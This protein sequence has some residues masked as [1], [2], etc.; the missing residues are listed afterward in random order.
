MKRVVFALSFLAL[1]LA[2]CDREAAPSAAEGETSVA[3]A[4]CPD[5]GARFPITGVCEGRAV[6]YLRQDTPPRDPPGDQFGPDCSW[7]TAETGFGPEQAVLYRALRCG[8]TTTTLEFGGGSH[9]AAL[10]IASS[11]IGGT[12]GVQVVQVFPL[13]SDMPPE[14]TILAQATDLSAE[15][16]AKC[17][18]LP[19]GVSGWP[20]DS[21]WITYGPEDAAA[22]P[23]DQPNAVCGALGRNDNESN[24]W[25]VFGGYAWFFTLGQ[26]E[27]GV[28]AGSLTLMTQG[29]DGTWAAA[30][31]TWLEE[32]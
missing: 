23:T 6:N 27:L 8:E 7:V 26:E 19:T 17:G 25:M 22:L 9:S 32:E 4:A 12:P 30:N 10:T 18:V 11:A 24:Y 5:D 14:A 13:S 1:G 31:G 15:E 21:L 29:A 3:E 16:Q 28:D 20:A 2:G